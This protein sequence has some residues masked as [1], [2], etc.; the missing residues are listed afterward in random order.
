MQWFKAFFD[1]SGVFRDDGYD[2]ASVRA[3]GKGGKQYNAKF[4]SGSKGGGGKGVAVRGGTTTRPTA[5]ARRSAAPA[6]ANAAPRGPPQNQK[7]SRNNK[8]SASAAVDSGS[9]RSSRPLRERPN[10][11]DLAPEKISTQTAGG[12]TLQQQ[13]RTDAAV[14]A[15]TA[16]NG[17]LKR[18]NADLAL[19]VGELEVA[20]LEIEKERDFYFEKL[21]NVEVMLQ[22]HQE[23][24]EDERDPVHLVNKVFKILYATA[25]DTILVSDDGELVGPEGEPLDVAAALANDETNAEEEDENFSS[26]LPADTSV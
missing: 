6:A 15:L 21:R 20:I 7:P 18:T 3:R 5:A 11:N 17:E 24:A 10:A 12:S 13:I 16:E 8:A 26:S 1:Q 19:K 23:K 9:P 2:P 25:D 22:V 4:G 14:A